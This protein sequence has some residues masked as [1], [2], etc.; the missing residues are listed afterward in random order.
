MV[1]SL[2]PSTFKGDFKPTWCPGCGNFG[3]L[4]GLDRALMMLELHPEEVV[5]C[6]GIGCSSRFPFFMRTYG[7]HSLHGR[8]LAVATGLKVARPDLTVVVT[9]GDGDA[10]SIGGNHFIH[11]LRRNVD[12][13]CIIM[14]NQVYGMTKGQTS[15]T[16]PRGFVT[17]S[18]PYGTQDAEV[19]PVWMALALGAT[20]VAQGTSHDP[21]QLAVLI[22]AGIEHKGMA[23]IN[24]TSPCVTFNRAC[25]YKFYQERSLNI[26]D[27]HPDYDPSDRLAAMEL[28]HNHQGQFP[29]GVLYR[30]GAPTFD[31]QLT[32][33]AD[34]AAAATVTLDDVAE[35]FR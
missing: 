11:A 1:A 12:L 34:R 19:N 6:S 9:I 13:T 23:V 15:P 21:K 24:V 2:R 18:T 16:S 32:A 7:F 28:V 26:L 29:L 4:A 22:R 14:D 33:M 8:A 10:V 20:Y 27:K 5:I 25:D 31:R 35:T 30:A 17:K 3:V